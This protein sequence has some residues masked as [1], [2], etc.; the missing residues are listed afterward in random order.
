MITSYYD[1][2]LNIPHATPE[3]NDAAQY[4]FYQG[5]RQ[6][7]L[8]GEL[9]VA[10]CMQDEAQ[11][12]TIDDFLKYWEVKSP[13]WFMTLF[14]DKLARTT[15]VYDLQKML[16]AY[17][18]EYFPLAKVKNDPLL[19]E[20]ELAYSQAIIG[21]QIDYGGYLVGKGIPHWVVL[22]KIATLDRAHAIVDIYNPFTNALEPY[23]WR[24]LM[25]ST[26]AY[27]QGLWIKRSI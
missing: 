9:C 21:V 14:R 22:E 3:T 4:M 11:T 20:L 2:V 17:E 23:S 6:Y 1:R 5:R 26:G 13:A 19:M 18:A 25:T 16:E 8:C 27:K 10:Y 24:E 12:Q 15:G 7:N